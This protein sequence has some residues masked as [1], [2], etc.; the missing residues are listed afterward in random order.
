MR[1]LHDDGRFEA[2][3]SQLELDQSL[4]NLLHNKSRSFT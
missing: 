3:P 4:H 1:E 2:R